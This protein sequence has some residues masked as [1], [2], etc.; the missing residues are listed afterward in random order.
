[1]LA[2]PRAEEYSR[3]SVRL[4]R[5]TSTQQWRPT[6]LGVN[7]LVQVAEAGPPSKRNVRMGQFFV[8][9]DVAYGW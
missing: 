9:F 7:D 2:I 3:Y 4:F 1:M 8:L 6:R 5:P